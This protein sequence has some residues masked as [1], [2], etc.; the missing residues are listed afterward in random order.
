LRSGAEELLNSLLQVW[1]VGD[2][3]VISEST[4]GQGPVVKDSGF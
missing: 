2:N 1:G 3:G 4:G